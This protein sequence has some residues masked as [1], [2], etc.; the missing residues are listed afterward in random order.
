MHRTRPSCKANSSPVFNWR[1]H[2]SH[3]KHA[4]WYT[5][6]LAFRTQCEEDMPFEHFEHTVPKLLKQNVQYIIIQ[7]I[8]NYF[9]R[10]PPY[11]MV[12]IGIILKEGLRPDIWVFLVPIPKTICFIQN[13]YQIYIYIFIINDKSSQS[14]KIVL[15]LN[16]I[17]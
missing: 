11:T 10:W 2:A 9:S 3:R 17:V 8:L 12:Q 16:Q 1:S 7:N 15:N 5:W 4:K 14:K 6:S 13:E